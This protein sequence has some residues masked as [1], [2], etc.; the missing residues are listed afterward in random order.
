MSV[1]YVHTNIIAQDWRK[2]ARF[3]Q[4]VFSCVPLLPERNQAGVWLERG[5]GVEGAALQ[6]VH[7][8][9]PGHGEDGPTLE[10]YS[11]TTMLGKP[12]AHANRQG[13]GHLAF[14]VDD[15]EGTLGAV[16]ERGGAALGDTVTSEVP[17][18]GRVTF[19]Y[20]TDPEGNILEL[21]QWA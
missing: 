8:R 6:G 20:A 13:L 5:T 10:I 21:Q 4:E 17:G 16:L 2:L 11:Y 3:Y 15:V 9:L 12:E 18:A 14:S 1:R 19:V 7:L